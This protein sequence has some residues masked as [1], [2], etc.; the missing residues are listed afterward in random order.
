MDKKTKIIIFLVSTVLS[1]VMILLSYFGWVRYFTIHM[2]PLEKYI[3]EYQEPHKIH[4]KGVKRIVISF[5]TTPGRMKK[6][7]PM[8]K[9]L[10][11]QTMRVDQIAMNLPYNHKGKKYE[12]PKVYEKVVNVFK[13]GRDLGTANSV[14]PTVKRE[15]ERDTVIIAVD[16]DQ[17]YGKDFVEN[18]VEE[19]KKHPNSVIEAKGGV[20]V[21]PEFFDASV[22]DATES[23]ND[24]W[25]RRHL[26][27]KRRRLEYN[28]NY[29]ALGF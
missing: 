27:A 11:D 19:S 13:I 8:L 16:D 28:E 26:N 14:V 5:S 4:D 6:I 21:R 2:Q 15:G 29:K 22:L 9:S 10:L 1:V 12:V 25:M 18:I 23:F 24:G 7:T 20:L 17:V 3:K